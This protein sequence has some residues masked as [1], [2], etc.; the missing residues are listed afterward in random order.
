MNIQAFQGSNISRTSLLTKLK[1]QS[2]DKL[3]PGGEE[4]LREFSQRLDEYE[5]S[6]VG[7]MVDSA[8]AIFEKESARSEKLGKWGAGLAGGGLLGMTGAVIAASFMTGGA[9]GIV[10]FGGLTAAF[11]GLDIGMG[12]GQDSSASQRIAT[13]ASQD[14]Q[15]MKAWSQ[16]S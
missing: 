5:G 2:V 4:Q 9:A 14:I 6:T 3:V 13:Q 11:L 7:E 12:I 8:Q 16:Q 1:E 15:T 10:A